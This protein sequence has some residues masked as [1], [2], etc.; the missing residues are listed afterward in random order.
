[1]FDRSNI[2]FEYKSPLIWQED[3][4]VFGIQTQSANATVFK[5][6]SLANNKTLLI[7]LVD[8]FIQAK[9]T[10]NNGFNNLHVFNEYKINDNKYHE[11]KFNVLESNSSFKVDGFTAKKETFFEKKFDP[12][13]KPYQ[14][15]PDTAK[16]I[17]QI[18]GS[19]KTKDSKE[20]KKD[21]LVTARPSQSSS[22]LFHTND[23]P[24]NGNIFGLVYNQF[25][26]V[27]TYIYYN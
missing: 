6:H 24:F 21:H 26:Y 19:T 27:H 7:E 18:G 14:I 16:I 17:V 20:N 23:K 12:L 13:N 1:M 2:I 4:L 8:G 9:L 25:R 15:L 22:S 10:D 3:F 11:I 5:A